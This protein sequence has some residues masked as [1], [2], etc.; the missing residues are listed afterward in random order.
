MLISPTEPERLRAIGRTSSIPESYGVDYLLLSKHL[1]QVGVQ[2]KEISDFVASVYDGRLTKELDMMGALGQGILLLEGRPQWTVDGK[3]VS[4]GRWTKA[5]HRG[6]IWSIHSRG[7]WIDTVPTLTDS[8]EY[9]SLLTKWCQKDR[10][11]SLRSRPKARSVWGT[12]NDRDWGIHA[13]QSFPGIG[14]EIAAAIYDK[15]G[16]VPLVWTVKPSELETVEGLGP[17]RVGRL[18]ELLDW[19]DDGDR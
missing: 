7:Y 16:G 18:I 13:L 8:I 15:F 17:K 1:G 19:M 4:N 6:T 9:L 3:L 2:R 10:H 5:Q 12:A 11:S 14:Y